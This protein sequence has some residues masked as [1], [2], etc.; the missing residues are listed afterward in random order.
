[1]PDTRGDLAVQTGLNLLI[2]LLPAMDIHHSRLKSWGHK[3]KARADNRHLTF[4]SE[5]L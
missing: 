1:M 4:T 5:G 3:A 2:M